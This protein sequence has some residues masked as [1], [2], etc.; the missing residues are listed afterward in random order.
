MLPIT[1]PEDMSKHRALVSTFFSTPNHVPVSF[2]YN[3][4]VI[5]GIPADWDPETHERRIDA[6]IVEF[7]YKGIDRKTGL[8]IRVE[9]TQYDDYPVMEW[10]AWFTNEGVKPTPIL[11]DIR[12]MDG[13]IVGSSAVLYHCNGDFYSADGYKVTET[14]IKAGEALSFAPNGGRPCDGAFPYYRILFDGWGLSI[15][16]GWPAQW[17]AR[18]EGR[19][20]GVYIQA[21]QELTHL[22]LLPGE[23]LRTPR[24]TLLTWTGDITRGVNL[25]RRWYRAHV[26]P[27]TNGQPI[28]PLLACAAT[29]EG[30]EFTAA[31]EEN[32]IRYIDKFINT[33]IK[34]DVWWIDA[35][36]YPCY[37]QSHERKWPITGS[38]EPDRKGS[39]MA[40][41]R[42]PRLQL[43]MARIFW[44]GSS[45]NE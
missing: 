22:R 26:L 13:I 16:I 5:T 17:S 35:G 24:I 1:N 15:A 4:K 33:G 37:N 45:R 9:C 43:K 6:N 40:L 39:R 44:F 12:V 14:P 7:V 21:G 11:R 41:G 32:Q 2:V 38:W 23:T 28:K 8:S 18:F 25:W 20:E 19:K 3:N 42:Y 34:P 30:E 27:R 31:T 36:W 29:D 10:V